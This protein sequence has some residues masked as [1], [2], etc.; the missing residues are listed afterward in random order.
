MLIQLEKLS[1]KI[2]TLPSSFQEEALEL[3]QLLTDTIQKTFHENLIMNRSVEE[4]LWGYQDPLLKFI[5]DMNIS[6]LD[7]V[8]PPDGFFQLEV[9]FLNGTTTTDLV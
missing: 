6:L 9:T 2:K 7:G 4:I 1:A 5:A 3:L 8:L